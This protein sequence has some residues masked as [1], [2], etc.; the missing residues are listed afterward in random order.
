MF[1]ELA[2]KDADIAIPTDSKVLRQLE[3]ESLESHGFGPKKIQKVKE[4]IEKTGE[5]WLRE[6]LFK[7]NNLETFFY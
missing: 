7:K 4:A 2:I 5:Y 6:S 3:K 1:R